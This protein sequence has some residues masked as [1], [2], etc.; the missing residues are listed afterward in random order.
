MKTPRMRVSAALTC[1]ATLAALAAGVTASDTKP[2]SAPANSLAPGQ[3]LYGRHCL[4]C[5]QADGGGVPNMQP[6]IKGGKWVQGD[7]RALALFVMTGGFDSGSRK[8]SDNGNVMPPFRQLPD[9]DLAQIL[10][11][12]RA[13]FGNGGTPVTAAQVA[14]MRASLPPSQ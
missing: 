2:A 10:S 1:V 5:H 4:S 12:I 8:D 7:S 14:E 13:K 9:A 11:Y 3:Q 6:P